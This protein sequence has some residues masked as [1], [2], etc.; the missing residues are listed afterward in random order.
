MILGSKGPVVAGTTNED[1]V[2]LAPEADETREPPETVQGLEA[3][4]AV[5]QKS[6][7]AAGTLKNLITQWR[8]FYRFAIKY[9]L[10]DWPVKTHTLCLYAQFLAYSFHSAKSVRNYLYGIRTLH[11]LTK[12]TPPDYK[13]IELKLTLRGLN[14]VLAR[15]VKRAQP[16]TPEILLD[17]VSLLDLSKRR[18]LVFWAIILIGFFGMLRK[19]N[20][21]PDKVDSFDPKKQLTRSHITFYQ[22]IAILNI[23]WAKNIQ[24]QQRVLHIPLFRIPDSPLCPVSVLRAL[25]NLP[26]KPHYPLFGYNGKVGYT[27]TQF[28]KRFRKLLK[29][30]GYR[31]MAFSSHSLRRG[32]VGFAHRAGISNSLIQVHGGWSSDC[33]KVYFDYPLEVRAAVALKMR[34]KIMNTKSLN[35]T[36]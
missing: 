5:T 16:V 26:G 32:S 33:F 13:D 36:F 15:P 12:T 21:I 4:L 14:K 18:D 29:K 7:Y 34:E 31:S 8:S 2:T 1:T 23:T 28:Q 17:L 30:A 20:L 35:V 24:H 19:S 10:L 6:A 9:K 25:T 3:D 22:D 27:Y 11:I